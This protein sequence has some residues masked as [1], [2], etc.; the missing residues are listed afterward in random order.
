MTPKGGSELLFQNLQKYLGLEELSKINLVLSVCNQNFLSKDK[1]NILWQHLSYDQENVQGMLTDNFTQ[2]VNQFVYVSNWQF[3]R[4]QEY[5]NAPI[6]NA[7]VIHNAIEPIDY[8]EKPKNK[9]KLIY[10]STPWRGLEVLL[11]AFKLLNRDDIELDVYSSTVIYGKHFMPNAYDYL[12]NR[13]RATKGI[14]YK[15]YATNKAVRKAVQSAHIFAYPSIF[16]ETSC[17]SAIEAGAAGCK[18]V[19]TDYGALKETCEN[20]ATYVQYQD[21]RKDLIHSY[22]EVLNQE[23]DNYWNNAEFK[24][25][26]DY[27]NNRYSWVSRKDDWNNLIENICAK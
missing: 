22:A 25:Q 27:F 21:N 8:I 13:C 20:Y 18:L 3:E 26:S 23:I 4:F 11:E 16:E 17:L 19:I 7:Q 5:F 2:N 14:N 24:Q 10:T 15:G 1:P 12:F 9:L 6:S